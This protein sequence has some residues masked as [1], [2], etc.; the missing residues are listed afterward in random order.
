MENT[1]QEKFDNTILLPGTKKDVYSKSAKFII[2][3]PGGGEIYHKGSNVHIY[4]EGGPKAP[5]YVRLCL[6]DQTLNKVIATTLPSNYNNNALV[7]HY[8]WNIPL[9]FN[10][11][12]THNFLIY[13]EDVPRD[14]WT[15]GQTFKIT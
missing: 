11:D 13:I 15:Y 3:N 10:I 9:V 2:L 1:N 8:M 14:T 4:W 7:G 6:V 12:V 5:Q